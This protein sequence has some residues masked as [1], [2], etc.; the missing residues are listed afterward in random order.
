MRHSGTSTLAFVRGIHR[1]PWPVTWKMFPF[2]DVIMICRCY[3]WRTSQSSTSMLTDIWTHLELFATTPICSIHFESNLSDF[4]W[5]VHFVSLGVDISS[6]LLLTD[7][8]YIPIGSMACIYHTY[9]KLVWPC[10][11][12]GWCDIV[13]FQ[14]C[15]QLYVPVF[16]MS[17][18]GYRYLWHCTLV[19]STL[20]R[21]AN[22]TGFSVHV[23]LLLNVIRYSCHY[24][25]DRILLHHDFHHES[26]DYHWD[27]YGH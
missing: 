1:S 15:F 23:V 5:L 13:W 6:P 3:S 7:L 20:N 4:F 22:R 21:I 12:I 8:G 19:S 9:Q 2:G 26:C 16:S 11:C 27:F 25:L 17:W 14:V 24:F 18:Y 10:W